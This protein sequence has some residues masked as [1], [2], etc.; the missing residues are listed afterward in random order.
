[1]TQLE[2]A[3]AERITPEMERVAAEERLDPEVLRSRV[4]RGTVV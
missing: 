4:A 2:S 3:L 1:M